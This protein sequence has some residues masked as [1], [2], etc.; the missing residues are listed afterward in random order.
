[1]TTHDALGYFARRY[2]IEAI[3]SVIPSLST[4]AQ[5]SAADADRLV[6]QIRREGVRV[7]FAESSVDS[8]LE[9]AIAEQGG[10][11]VGEPL[12]AD[13]LGPAG[14]GGAT[15]LESLAANANAMIDGFTGGRATC[16]VET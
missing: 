10:A 15:Y 14:S 7:V 11:R 6:D 8:K 3:G 16:R 2:G 13:T 1:V 12:W 9:R 5:P 4:E